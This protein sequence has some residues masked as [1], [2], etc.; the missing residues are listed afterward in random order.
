MNNFLHKKV[1]VYTLMFLIGLLPVSFG[2]VILGPRVIEG[3]IIVPF[4]FLLGIVWIYS[5]LPSEEHQWIFRIALV[6]ILVRFS[7]SFGTDIFW[8]GF[9]SRSD[10]AAY[11]PHAHAIATAWSQR[12]LVSYSSVVDSPVGAPGY[13]YLSAAVF[14]LFNYNTLYIKLLNGLFGGIAVVYTY[15]IGLQLYGVKVARFGAAFTAFMPSILLWTSQNL[16][17]SLVLFLS[18]WIFWEALQ[19]A[20]RQL[21]RLP[22]LIGV[23]FCLLTVRVETAIGLAIILATTQVIHT[24]G[25]VFLKLSI[26]ILP[27]L[28]IGWLL[29]QAGYGFLGSNF[30]E[31]RLSLEAINQKRL[32]T[33]YGGSAIQISNQSSSLAGF[34]GYLPFAV[35]NYLLRPWPWEATGSVLQIATIPESVFVWY[36]IFVLSAIGLIQSIKN[37]PARTAPL[38]LYVIS[39]TVAA[40]PQYGN[41]GT[42]YRHRVQLWPFF[43]LLAGYAWY[44]WRSASRQ[45]SLQTSV[46]GVQHSV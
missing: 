3:F 21:Y 13:V 35:S 27:V 31:D 7:L 8:S 41:L 26:G 14:W 10:G 42:A 34:I 12:G 24:Q 32:V 36:P 44:S 37:L 46:I 43:F 16:K 29:E 25:N 33:A 28:G 4:L 15:K 17:D 20:Q 9:E 40:A 19:V 38:W 23:L 6:A 39:A 11:G 45:G 5:I 1:I 2:F 30:L 18:M 22:L